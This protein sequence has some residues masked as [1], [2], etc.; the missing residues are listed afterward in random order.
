MRFKSVYIRLRRIENRLARNLFGDQRFGSAERNVRLF[1]PDFGFCQ[2]LARGGQLRFGER[3]VDA[4]CGAVKPADHLAF[5]D[6]DAF[7]YEYFLHLARNFCGNGGAA[8]RG[9]VPEALRT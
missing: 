3:Q 1:Q 9:D 6:R 2:S 8:P 4:G 5:N 7:F